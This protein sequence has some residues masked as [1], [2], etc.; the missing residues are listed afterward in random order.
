MASL[1]GGV[2]MEISIHASNYCKAIILA[3]HN[4]PCYLYKSSEY[5]MGER[6][7]EIGKDN[8]ESLIVIELTKLREMTFTHTSTDACF[9]LKPS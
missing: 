5:T 8:T 3:P 7:I 6:E 1:D 4:I 2:P 9:E